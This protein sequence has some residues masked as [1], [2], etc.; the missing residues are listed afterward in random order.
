M[1]LFAKNFKIT[2]IKFSNCASS[3]RLCTCECGAFILFCSLA[4]SFLNA[5][6]LNSVKSAGSQ[7]EVYF[8]VQYF[9]LGLL[10]VLVK[11][12]LK[13]SGSEKKFIQFR[14]FLF[15]KIISRISRGYFIIA[16]AQKSRKQQYKHVGCKY[17]N[18]PY[19]DDGANFTASQPAS[20]TA[21]LLTITIRSVVGC[22]VCGHF[23]Q[24]MTE[25]NINLLDSV[26][27]QLGKTEISFHSDS[28]LQNRRYGQARFIW[29]EAILHDM[30]FSI[31]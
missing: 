5:N 12:Q 21:S 24:N 2:K 7:T 6:K 15:R 14:E 10:R 8:I 23:V 13:N 3:V 31:L 28:I 17:A 1:N 4:S 29:E 9:L 20:R 18:H 26:L 11:S 30:F 19:M 16:V 25:N 27:Y 22:L